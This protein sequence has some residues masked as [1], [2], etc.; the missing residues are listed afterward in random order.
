MIT[1]PLFLKEIANL[2]KL[3]PSNYTLREL[4]LYNSGK[5]AIQQEIRFIGNV[6]QVLSLPKTTDIYIQFNE[7][8]NALIKLEEG[9]LLFT[10]YRLFLTY[11]HT[12]ELDS[13]N[14]PYLLKLLVGKDFISVQY[15]TPVSKSFLEIVDGEDFLILKGSG[16]IPLPCRRASQNPQ[17]YTFDI[18]NHNQIRGLVCS[19]STIFV[20]AYLYVYQF[21]MREQ[22]Y[23]QIWSDTI[24]LPGGYTTVPF[25]L[26]LVSPNLQ[27]W[28]DR[29]SE[30]NWGLHLYAK[31]WCM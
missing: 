20:P 30:V 22:V 15:P 1:D 9:I 27:F 28:V 11:K 7:I 12:L 26:D 31:L 18:S 10:F 24:E 4:N 14:E 21:F 29:D 25:I 5:D 19:E 6:I 8:S 17:P 3:K 13:N 16:R 2:K 23:S